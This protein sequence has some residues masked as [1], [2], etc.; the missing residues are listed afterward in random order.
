[1]GLGKRGAAW[2]ALLLGVVGCAGCLAAIAGLWY[3]HAQLSRMTAG[4]FDT[5]DTSLDF[6]G[7]KLTQVRT[8]IDQA[9]LTTDEVQ[10]ALKQW[11][12]ET[13]QARMAAR[14]GAAEKT[15]RLLSALEQAD[16]WL[17][18][19]QSSAE[20]VRKLLAL[21]GRT[22]NAL[23][24]RITQQTATLRS[25][26][27]EAL[28]R[29]AAIEADLTGDD[30]EGS[31]RQRIEQAVRL[32]VRV[33]ATLG[34]VDEQLQ[35]LD[36]SLARSRQNLQDYKALTLHRLLLAA[37]VLTVLGVWMAAGQVALCLLARRS[38]RPAA[39]AVPG[40]TV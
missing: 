20:T 34:V 2:A 40:S 30:E 26:L 19:S 7:Q 8:R 22:D 13:V 3:A 6:A 15:Q 18:V 14:L 23:L 35:Q 21:F 17:E 5:V 24:D 28:Q 11:A 36:T 4:A 9:K 33:A 32:A 29:V 38:L 31:R 25:E 39:P 37:V 10:T 16:Q 1:M 12:G 27:G